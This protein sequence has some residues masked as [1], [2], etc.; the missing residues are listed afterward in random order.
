MS[1]YYRDLSESFKRGFADKKILEF[2]EEIG[3]V[4][5]GTY[6]GNR[7]QMLINEGKREIVLTIKTMVEQPVENILAH[8]VEV[9]RE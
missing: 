1:Q 8:F 2:L 4:S 9:E 3:Y 7:D 5:R 6:D